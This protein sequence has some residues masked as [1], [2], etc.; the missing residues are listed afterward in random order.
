MI[1]TVYVV[2]ETYSFDKSIVCAVFKTAEEAEA[3]VEWRQ[4]NGQSKAVFCIDPA[5]LIT[6]EGK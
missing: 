3:Y 1:P 4:D 5:P 2:S 6:R